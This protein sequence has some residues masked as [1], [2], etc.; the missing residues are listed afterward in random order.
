M[1]RITSPMSSAVLVLDRRL[2]F[3]WTGRFGS[4]GE[5]TTAGAGAVAAVGSKDWR[6]GGVSS[7][8][9][10]CGVVRSPGGEATG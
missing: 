3:H 4:R 6:G 8:T 2:V 9:W 1:T 5:G 7:A 10:L